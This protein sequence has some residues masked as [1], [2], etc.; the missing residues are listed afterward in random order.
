MDMDWIVIQL[1]LSVESHTILQK[2]EKTVDT[3]SIY[4]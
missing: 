1:D 4:I 3:I 2:L